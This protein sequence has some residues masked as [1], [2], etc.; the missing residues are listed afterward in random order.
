MKI[1]FDGKRAISNMTGLGNYSRLI[2]EELSR[3]HPEDE[4]TVFTPKAPGDSPRLARMK[5][6]PNI[7]FRTPAKGEAPFGGSIWRTRGLTRLLKPEGIQLFHG[8]SNELPLNIAKAGIPS[9]VTMHDVIYR[10][11]PYC[12]K[13]IDRLIY[14]M[15]YG[16]SC[17]NATHIIAVSERTKLDVMHYYGIADEKISVIYQGCDPQFHTILPPDKIKEITTLYSL[18]EHYLLQVGTIE[19]RKNAL[20]SVQALA[21]LPEHLHLVLVGRATPY[22]KEMEKEAGRNG[23]LHR[24]HR[25][26]GL[27]FA[28]LPA[29]YQG[30]QIALYP[31]R[32]EGFG[33][34][35]LE[36]L[37]GGTPCIA[38]TGS[39]LEEA[40]GEAALYVNPDNPRQLADTILSILSNE[41]LRRKMQEEGPRH[42]ARFNTA[43][44]TQSLYALYSRLIHSPG[45]K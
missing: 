33:I 21:A 5:S 13:P 12:Y 23:T 9:I 40:G 42:A 29:L 38:A 31:S 6:A 43:D 36:A 1:G 28:H 18:P 8:L 26:E 2:L 37:A 17:R 44:L 27:P 7:S 30:A 35:V 3:E 20:L 39:C 22:W 45:C 19:R 10:R 32:Y 15:K 14:D 16:A 11:L 34:P 24:I 25:L 41:S 4:L